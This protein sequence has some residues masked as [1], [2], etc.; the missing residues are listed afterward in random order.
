MTLLPKNAN[1]LSLL[2]Y[3]GKMRFSRN[4]AKLR[5]SSFIINEIGTW[6]FIGAHR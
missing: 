5:M 1:V 6:K 2:A 4:F 3:N